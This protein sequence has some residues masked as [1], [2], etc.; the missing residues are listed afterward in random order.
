MIV[1]RVLAGVAAGA[2]IAG[3]AIAGPVATAEAAPAKEWTNCGPHTCTTYFTKAQ[4]RAYANYFSGDLARGG[5]IA[6]AALCGAIAG[7]IRPAV[8]V[9]AGAACGVDSGDYSVTAWVEATHHAVDAG[10]CLQVEKPRKGIPLLK[11]GYTTHPSY[12]R[13]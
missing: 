11:P 9:I 1:K 3:G 6:D 2:I 7:L 4:S 13:G 5:K 10:G 8:G 12:C